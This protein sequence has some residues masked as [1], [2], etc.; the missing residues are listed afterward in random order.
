M[1]RLDRSAEA[2]VVIADP[3]AALQGLPEPILLDEWQE[4]PQV[5]GAVKRACDIGFRPGRFILTGL[6]RAQ[7]QTPTWPGTGRITR[8]RMFP[9][10]VG[11]QLG[12]QTVPFVDRL[13][14]NLLD[15][16]PLAGV[17]SETAA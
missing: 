5:L 17:S 12:V 13:A 1:I 11:E 3:D 9:L 4:F 16:A 10:T 8:V 2:S 15:G 14:W 7:M 6:V